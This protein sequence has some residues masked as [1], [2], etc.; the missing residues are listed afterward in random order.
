MK[1][2]FKD[3][4][5]DLTRIL[6]AAVNGT[7]MDGAAMDAAAHDGVAMDGAAM[8]AAAAE[9][10][11][12]MDGTGTKDAGDASRT[13]SGGQ[14][15]NQNARKHG[16]YSKSLTPEQQEAIVEARKADILTEE[17]A[18]MRVKVQALVNDPNHDTDQVFRGIGLLARIVRIDDNLRFGP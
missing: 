12:A 13:K 10:A 15:G 18:F 9:D 1:D 4:E 6:R 5:K 17:I 3:L 16:F 2:P 11:A 14:P 8:D 7:D